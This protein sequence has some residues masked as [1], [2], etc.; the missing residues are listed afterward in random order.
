MLIWYPD[1]LLNSFILTFLLISYDNFLYT[2]SCHR[3]DTIFLLPF[4][5]GSFYFWFWLLWL[6]LTG[7]CWKGMLRLGCLPA[8]DLRGKE[9][10]LRSDRGQ[11]WTYVWWWGSGPAARAGAS[12]SAL[13]LREPCLSARGPMAV[14]SHC[15]CLVRSWAYEMQVYSWRSKQQLSPTGQASDRVRGPEL[16]P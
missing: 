3:H 1:T 6:G 2:R 9:G 7:Q 16:G 12:S 13:Q 14:G 8:P 5:S 4:Q 11:L 10:A 15:L